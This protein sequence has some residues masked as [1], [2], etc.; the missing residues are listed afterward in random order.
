MFVRARKWRKT[1]YVLLLLCLSARLF[2]GAAEAQVNFMAIV[3]DSNQSQGLVQEVNQNS[4]G[5]FGPTIVDR[6]DA[7]SIP[8]R[9]SEYKLY[10]KYVIPDNNSNI[11]ENFVH[12]INQLVISIQATSYYIKDLT[13]RSLH[14]NSPPA[15]VTTLLLTVFMYLFIIRIGVFRNYGENK[16]IGDRRF[17]LQ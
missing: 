15:P 14:S 7:S 17:S 16:N 2:T 4:L 12:A 6:R 8:N 3:G 9:H 1:F 11:R 13:L 5:V 10:K